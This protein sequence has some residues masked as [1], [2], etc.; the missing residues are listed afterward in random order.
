MGHQ[1]KWR[2]PFSSK[3]KR[4]VVQT[5]AFLAA[6]KLH[7]YSTDAAHRCE[8]L[9]RHS[10]V[11]CGQ[12]AMRGGKFCRHHGGLLSAA[13]AEAERYGRPVIIVRKPRK[14]ALANMGATAVRPQGAP[15]WIDELGPYQRGRAIEAWENRLMAPDAWRREVEMPRYRAERAK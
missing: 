14:R 8:G 6:R 12:P 2:L 5:V 11:P 9:T 1:P 13:K 7:N 10:K 3:P 15:L 4:P